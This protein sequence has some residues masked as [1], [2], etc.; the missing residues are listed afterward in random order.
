MISFRTVFTLFF[1]F[2]FSQSFSGYALENPPLETIAGGE[3]SC[4]N[5]ESDKCKHWVVSIHYEDEN[6]QNGFLCSGSLIASNYVLT[7]A[8]CKIKNAKEYIIKDY[9]KNIIGTA[10][11]EEFQSSYLGNDFA[12]IKLK[13][14]V[15]DD[16]GRGR[17]RRF[18]NYDEAYE[19]L[20][21]DYYQSSI[22]GYGLLGVDKNTGE[23]I[24]NDGTQ[25][26]ADVKIFT[27][28]IDA[29]GKEGLMV[30]A[31]KN[32]ALSPGVI[33]MGDSGGPIIWNDTIIGVSSWGYD[34]LKIKD[35]NDY[36]FFFF[37]DVTGKYSD[38]GS[39]KKHDLGN[40]FS[41]I[42]KQVW[43]NNPDWNTHL[44]KRGKYV[45]VEGWGRKGSEIEVAYSIKNGKENV[46]A[47]GKADSRGK[48]KCY[49]QHDNFFV[50]DINEIEEYKVTII[51][52]E[53]NKV[54]ESWEEDTV[55]AKISSISE[56]FGIVYPADESTVI[57]KNFIVRGYADPGSD[58]KLIIQ[59]N[60]DN[61]EIYTQDKLCEGLEDEEL[62]KTEK[63]GL[64]SCT[65]KSE[66]IYEIESNNY[67]IIASQNTGNVNLHDQVNI[68]LKPQEYTELKLDQDNKDQSNIYRKKVEYDVSYAN[69]AS[70][71]CIFNNKSFDCRN[72]KDD[73]YRFYLDNVSGDYN[74]P[75]PIMVYTGAIQ[76][77]KDTDFFD[78][79]LWYN[80]Y[81]RVEGGYFEP[82]FL[83]ENKIGNPNKISSV[84]LKNKKISGVGGDS[85]S[86]IE[87]N[88]DMI[89][90]SEYSICM[91]KNEN[92]LLSLEASICSRQENE[93]IYLKVP[94][95][96]GKDFEEIPI[97]YG[98]YS[99]VNGLKMNDFPIWDIP[100]L[101]T[102]KDGFYYI[103]VTDKYHPL[104]LT[105][106]K[107]TWNSISNRSYFQ[108]KT[109]EVKITTPSV[110]ETDTVGI[111]S[112]LSGS[113]NEPGD[114]VA[115]KRRKI[116][117]SS[118]LKENNQDLAKEMFI[119]TGAVVSDSGNWQC[120]KPIIF[121]AGTYELTAE[122]IKEGK[123]V[124]TD[125]THITIKD[126]NDDEPE[127]KK[128]E[129]KN[130]KNN[131]IVDPDNPITFSGTFSG[132]GGG[133]GGGGGGFGGFLSSIFGAIF[134]AFEGIASL[135]SGA[136]G[137]FWE[138]MIHPG[139]I[140]GGDTYTMELQETQNG[141]NVGDPIKWTF[142]VPMRIT[143]PKPD[144]QYRLHDEISI[145]GQGSP[146]QLVF[147]TGS[148]Y[149]LPPEKMT[150]PISSEG[151]ICTA[152][153]DKGGKW[154]CPNNPVMKATN[155][156][157][158]FLY[159]AQ[160][161]KTDS[162]QLG[163]LGDTYEKT[164][165]V[166]RKY[167]VT[168]TKI[169]IIIPVHGA[170]ITTLPF[171][172]SGTGEKGAQVYVEGFGG[173]KDCN[174]TVDSSG[175][176]SCGSYQPEEGKYSVSADQFIDNAL[177]SKAVISFEIQTKTVKPVTIT[178]PHNGGIFQYLENILP[179]GTGEPG[180]TVCLAQKSLSQIC[181]DGVTIN[182]QGHWEW[183]YGLDT[184]VKGE[185]KLVAT[186][187]LGKVRQSTAKV[188]FK[189]EPA[190][191]ETTL[192][193]ETPKE[194]E[195]IKT[196]S[197]MFSGT[198]PSNAKTVTVQGFG[199]HGDCIAKLNAEDYT[200]SC[201]PYSSV[202]GDYDVAVVDDADSQINRS[203]KVRYGDNLQMR[204]LN[205]TE[206]EQIDK[207]SYWIS[208]KGQAGARVTVNGAVTC[209]V[210]VDEN[211]DWV[212]PYDYKSIPGS[213][214]LL[215]QQWVDDVPSGK[216]VTRNYE[217][218]YGMSDITID[219]TAEATCS[220][221][222][223][224]EETKKP[225]IYAPIME[226]NEAFSAL[227][228]GTA[229]KGMYV[230]LKVKRGNQNIRSCGPVQASEADGKWSCRIDDIE[231]GLYHLTATQAIT[232]N[233][234][235]V[236]SAANQDIYVTHNDLKITF[237]QD[238][239][240]Y[241]YH[242]KYDHSKWNI[243]G[244]GDPGAEVLVEWPKQGFSQ[245][246]KVDQQGNW[247]VISVIPPVGYSTIKASYEGKR[248]G[249]EP[250]D[251]VQFQVAGDLTIGFHPPPC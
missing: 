198:M 232:S 95:K 136:F 152:T 101:S 54:S 89:L 190:P 161:K 24:K 129:V 200:W 15:S 143:E 20:N 191:G 192:T 90:P 99:M 16:Y 244:V 10:Q 82:D 237:P 34:A 185:Q 23:Q 154:L 22:Y 171:T 51:A 121:P 57:T 107:K 29:K 132:S 197:Y 183:V 108:I 223:L 119:C 241:C 73:K 17:I 28:A 98:N 37:S 221:S 140:L 179:K 68:L 116:D 58:V 125:V 205:P 246:T 159:A 187:F 158:F 31:S 209:D 233:S 144:A 71:V 249:L 153:V 40:W 106:I 35:K 111:P 219:G 113:A 66:F 228:T 84:E 12:L 127:K 151:I 164:S 195:V 150:L 45:F 77:I 133:G 94:L 56:E 222:S 60:L 208:G 75:E 21:K 1:L 216:P 218:I 104:G 229:T 49:I 70:A 69:E 19:K 9:K 157:K 178:Q 122:L 38:A 173:A 149:L 170:K 176:W 87:M 25:R 163:Q 11:S 48:W 206:G 43:I 203:F 135:F 201:G 169:Q 47:C 199:G 96:D 193:V 231:L 194:D 215:G 93:D 225:V 7:A 3:E 245:K 234:N 123:I 240:A 79:K 204:I 41:T 39:S 81:L 167:E 33:Q 181:Q 92:S 131:S 6:N 186:A 14:K 134:G 207:Y 8:H 226:N 138:F 120:G 242:Y 65:V 235:P 102:L 147:V 91:K 50:E 160:Y 214:K 202:P 130:P 115:I 53:V 30:E 100:L 55:Q 141:V 44:S 114:E 36:P 67:K 217:V 220:V 76:K 172:I 175:K 27:T 4:V 148:E 112:F 110:G 142:T 74:N 128:F 5:I 59:S 118:E 238:N 62:I 155:E 180:T 188:T 80:K 97:R 124:A 230:S 165:Q 248:C 139:D 250:S 85:K 224:N 32:K 46:Y 64:W 63:Y 13:E 2:Y 42:M 212:C 174:T 156:G 137:F 105:N 126:E 78:K 168:K 177:D 236:G 210:L 243:T 162:T 145:K 61:E 103:E 184:S 211:Q 196:P 83:N 86:Y 18:F 247:S 239:K 251:S 26:R 182:E 213:H 72:N 146:N 117:L 166:T 88:G 52:R 189:I 109:P 227:I